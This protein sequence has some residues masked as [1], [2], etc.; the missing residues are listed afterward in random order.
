[1]GYFPVSVAVAKLPEA[2]VVGRMYLL[3]V[4]DAAALAPPGMYV[5]DSASWRCIAATA[6][7]ALGDMGAEPA[8]ALLDGVDYTAAYSEN[9][10]SLGGITLAAPGRCSITLDNTG[11]YTAPGEPGIAPIGNSSVAWDELATDG[12]VLRLE[13]LTG[14]MAGVC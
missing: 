10:A 13:N 14:I 4:P 11:G 2:P 1:M 7:Y 8:W 5:H 6:V 3:S 9:L 12:I